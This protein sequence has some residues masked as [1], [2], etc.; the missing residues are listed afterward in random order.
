MQK[1]YAENWPILIDYGISLDKGWES[2]QSMFE[3]VHPR[4]F[5]TLQ[6]KFSQLT[7]GEV[8]VCALLKF[9]LGT[10]TIADLQGIVVDSVRMKR[11]RTRQKMGQNSEA[12]LKEVLIGM[13]KGIN[14]VI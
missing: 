9:D 1:N 2:F 13:E 6:A 10:K 8:Q 5:T 11:Y 14:N 7:A 12:K 3:Q 4:F